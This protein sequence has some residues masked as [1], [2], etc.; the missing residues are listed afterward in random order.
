MTDEWLFNEKYFDCMYYAIENAQR[1]LD[2]SIILV[3][4]GSYGHASSLAVLGQ[5]ECVKSVRYLIA[6][7]ESEEVDDGDP[8]HRDHRVKHMFALVFRYAFSSPVL[9]YLEE[10]LE[11]YFKDIPKV[12]KKELKVR[13]KQFN[14]KS[15][16]IK[17]EDLSPELIGEFLQIV[18]EVLDLPGFFSRFEK[19]LNED[20]EKMEKIKKY[21]EDI[22]KD[23]D[24]IYYHKQL[25]KVKMKGF[26]IDC[27][28]KGMLIPSHVSKSE[29]QAQIINLQE[30]LDK[31][32]DAFGYQDP[33]CMKRDEKIRLTEVMRYFLNQI[34]NEPMV[35]VSNNENK[36]Q[37]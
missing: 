16:R 6:L 23:F 5:E 28:K 27:H 3:K 9:R 30:V 37:H 32:T 8:F 14:K 1:F 7:L 12:K 4:K 24:L 31:T 36:I 10:S 29:A 20:P 2:D 22:K 19:E 26:Y 15:K 17:T 25:D 34:S 18:S 13:I 35:L 21:A 33:D 11:E